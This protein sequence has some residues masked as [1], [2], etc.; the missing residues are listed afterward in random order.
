MKKALL[1]LLAGVSVGLGALGLVWSGP[2]ARVGDSTTHGGVIVGPGAPEQEQGIGRQLGLGQLATPCERPEILE[3]Y[4]APFAVILDQAEVF[5]GRVLDH[6][7]DV[8]R[9]LAAPGELECIGGLAA[10][11]HS[12]PPAPVRS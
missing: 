5:A 7:N 4:A 6:G 10:F 8:H 1:A 3:A 11:T 12:P 2:A 9:R